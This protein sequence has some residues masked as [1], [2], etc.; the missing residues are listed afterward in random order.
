MKR[1]KRFRSNLD[2]ENKKKEKTPKN[3][4]TLI[5]RLNIIISLFIIVLIGMMFIGIIYI[6]DIN[7]TKN[8]N[9]YSSAEVFDGESII[10]K[11]ADSLQY[12]IIPLFKDVRAYVLDS[13]FKMNKSPLEGSGE[14]FVKYCEEFNAPKGCYH[15]PAITKHETDL[16]KYHNSAEMFNCLGWGGGYQYR[17]SF[18]NFEEMIKTSLDVLVNQYGN[19]Y[20]LNPSE[21]EDVFC[22]PEDWCRGWGNRIVYF[23]NSIDSYSESLGVGK[24]SR[25]N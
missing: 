16:C 3:H 11:T 22:G 24:L 18:S 21:M 14:L 15:L 4:I 19:T 5:L 7:N 8:R 23:Y 13:Y 20:I 12:Q 25:F 2:L 10:K 17:M 6:A 9:I 1:I